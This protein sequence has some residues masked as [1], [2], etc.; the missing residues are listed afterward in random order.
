MT[1][2]CWISIYCIFDFGLKSQAKERG[3]GN[4]IK[5]KRENL[6]SLR[7]HNTSFVLM[8]FL[9]IINLLTL[10]PIHLPQN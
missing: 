1:M 10:H 2:N 7:H 4:A 6:F 8:F 3:K 9:A 5:N